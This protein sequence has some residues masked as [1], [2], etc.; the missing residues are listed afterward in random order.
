M[1]SRDEEL[2]A[3]P[4]WT[5]NKQKWPSGVRTIGM[6]EM[7]CLGIDRLGGLYWDGH[8]IEVRRFSL[9]FWQRVGAVMV[10]GSAFVAAVAT[11]V[12]AWS[13]ACGLSWIRL[14]CGG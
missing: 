4:L 13:A 11:A 6:D 7:D 2:R 14:A 10:A 9:T 8:P 1:T 12:H 5:A 3:V